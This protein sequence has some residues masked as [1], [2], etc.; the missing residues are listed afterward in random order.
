[1]HTWYRAQSTVNE[2]RNVMGTKGVE[3]QIGRAHPRGCKG[4]TEGKL[5]RGRPLMWSRRR[6]MVAATWGK[7]HVW[8]DHS[9]DQH[10]SPAP[11]RQGA[12]ESVT[13]H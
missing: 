3:Y 4:W 6:K 1:M 7:I 2:E 11:G 10:P 13:D 8:M 12:Q 5:R 9:N